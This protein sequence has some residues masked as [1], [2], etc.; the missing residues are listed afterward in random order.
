MA[1]EPQ[2]RR[3]PEAGKPVPLGVV[4]LGT[5]IPKHQNCNNGS[6]QIAQMTQMAR[7]R[8]AMAGSKD[9]NAAELLAAFLSGRPEQHGAAPGVASAGGR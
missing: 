7:L 5:E 6:P 4:G 9:A 1:G 2:A 3:P 8:R